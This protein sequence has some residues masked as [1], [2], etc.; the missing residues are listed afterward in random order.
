MAQ[1]PSNEEAKL[2][3]PA[4]RPWLRRFR[5]GWLQLSFLALLL[6]A[7]A[8]RLW[9]LDARTMHYDEAIHVHFSWKLFKGEGFV[10]SP[11]MHGPFQI[12]LTALVF[13]L[14]GDND[15]T[16]R[17]AYVVFGTAL[18]GLPY[19]L[20]HHIGGMGAFFTGLMITL[21]PTL[22]YFSRFGRNDI[23]MAFLTA[24]TLV[25]MWRYIVS[26]K[27]R[28]LFLT[29]MVLALMFATKET[30]YL[31][32][33]LFGGIA[34]L[35]ALPDLTPWTLGR[36]PTRQLGSAARFLLVLV[37]LTLPQWA[38]ASGLFQEMFGL[39]LTNR[40]GVEDGIVGAPQWAEPFVRLPVLEF[41]LWLHVLVGVLF[42]GFLVRAGLW[43]ISPTSLPV[44][45]RSRKPALGAGA[46]EGR[47]RVSIGTTP[48]PVGTASDEGAIIDDRSQSRLRR[49]LESPHFDSLL[50]RAFVPLASVAA[51]YLML[52]R[53]ISDLGN[54]IGSAVLDFASAGALV[55][56]AMAVLWLLRIPWEKGGRLLLLPP[57][58]ALPYLAMFTPLVDV[59]S[60]VRTVLPDGINLDASANLIPVN[61]LVAGTLLFGA[62]LISV[63]FGL[64][65]LGG[66]WL[67]CAGIF[68][69]TW[70]TLYTT[71]YAN[72]SGIFS[73]SWLG[74]GYWVA[75]QEVARG[76]QPWYYYFVGMGVYELLPI[77]FGIAAGVYYLRRAD[78]LGMV[79]VLW[80]G[81]TFMAYTIASEKMPWLL[82]NVTLPF[83]F[84]AGKFL[85]DL[86]SQI[87]WGDVLRRG[88]VL[89]LLLPSAGIVV[90]V[91]Q[92]YS[93][94]HTAQESNGGPSP[95]D[96]GL[97]VVVALLAIATASLMRVAGTRAGIAA[98]AAL[99]VAALMLGFGTISAFR[100][101]YTYDDS[102]VEIL[103]Y[104]QGSSDLPKTF[105]ELEERVFSNS[106]GEVRVDYDMWYPFQW[107]IRNAQEEGH[108]SFA[109]FKSEGEDGW[110]SSCEPAS[111]DE[112][113]AALLL[114]A[115][116]IRPN[117]ASLSR[118][119]TGGPFRDLIWFPESYRRPN[120]DRAEEG[121]V[122]GLR[123]LPNSHQLSLDFR[124]FEDVAK[125]RE[126]WADALAYLINRK[127]DD[128][129]YKSEYYS[130]LPM[131]PT[132]P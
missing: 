61:Y 48:R 76:N 113:S 107:Y 41:P 10:H 101:A 89:L 42:L 73:G 69:A 72:I 57:L 86:A 104:A 1:I 6:L 4:S 19:Y 47:R 36:L 15:H 96:W 20:R 77:S 84:L 119:D 16:A 40:Q 26:G 92:V 39:S 117:S 82:V 49:F 12:E 21:S 64:R 46:W 131:K 114:T 68:Y 74:M 14:L 111:H 23:I 83:I 7:L 30:S 59:A 53:P 118:F 102:N 56:V 87:Y 37:T 108:L 90:L 22:L 71:F 112:D 81:L 123:A 13:K 32:V 31:V 70:V 8:L 34:F 60:V 88:Q 120:E 67:L 24:S 25:L 58:L 129:W 109:C 94:A 17:L 3:L 27:I 128:E 98:M 85:G 29:A 116:H 62:L 75:Q 5:I 91:Y 65:W 80:A 63:Y 130:Y 66:V 121:F 126:S 79:L 45:Q 52:F 43:K 38:A 18:V 95:E 122:W 106:A 28:Y 2:P 11:W 115:P 50:S 125:S 44:P 97:L 35:L 55:I 99:G 100:A 93:Y 51:T 132:I 9:E 54:T 124:Y 33:G 127:L 103:A 78:V 110:N 105:E